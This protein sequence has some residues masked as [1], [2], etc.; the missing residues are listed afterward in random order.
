MS[1]PGVAAA[2]TVAGAAG[3]A[4]VLLTWFWGR[5]MVGSRAALAGALVLPAV[6]LPVDPAGLVFPALFA[7]AVATV[8]E[9][10]AKLNGYPSYR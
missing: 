7:L 1:A 5:R 4:T 9:L 6:V 2:F 10:L 3:F 8:F